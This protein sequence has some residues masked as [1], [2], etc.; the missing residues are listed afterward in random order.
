MYVTERQT[1]TEALFSLHHANLTVNRLHQQN[2]LARMTCRS[3]T[4]FII[5]PK[6]RTE[7]W[8]AKLTVI[9]RGEV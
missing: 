2:T 3:T 8:A 4:V 6:G 9:K 5:V 1:I 7:M